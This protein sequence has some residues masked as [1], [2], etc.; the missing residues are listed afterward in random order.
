M[1]TFLLAAALALASSAPAIAAPDNPHAHVYLGHVEDTGRFAEPK[2]DGLPILKVSNERT[3]D[4]AFPHRITIVARE[5]LTLRT[6]ASPHAGATG[7][8]PRGSKVE[9][10]AVHCSF[11]FAWGEVDTVGTIVLAEETRSYA[12]NGFTGRSGTRPGDAVAMQ[13]PGARQLR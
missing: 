13:S 4:V 12:R 8:L 3:T 2:F 6:S 7:R 1:K 5:G 10:V 9:L 11:G